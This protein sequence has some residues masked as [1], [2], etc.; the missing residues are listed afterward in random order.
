VDLRVTWRPRGAA[1]RWELYAEA[2]NVLNRKN[3][4]ALD[5]RLEHNPTSDRPRVVEEPIGSI[6]ILPTIGVRFRF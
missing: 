5:P 4:S 3:A 1:G 6:P 2:L